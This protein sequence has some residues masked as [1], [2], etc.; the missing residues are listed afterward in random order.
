MDGGFDTSKGEGQLEI[1]KTEI[2]SKA[3]IS[4][5]CMSRLNDLCIKICF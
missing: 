4:C 3:L 5:Y 2:Y 1:T